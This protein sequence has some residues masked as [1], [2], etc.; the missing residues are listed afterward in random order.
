MTMSILAAICSPPGDASDH[1]FDA[2]ARACMASDRARD[3]ALA[4]AEKLRDA[5][6][7]VGVEHYEGMIHVFFAFAGVVDRANEA[8]DVAAAALRDAL[9]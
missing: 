8:M 6:V 3:D 9:A 4:Y 7:P 2:A 5:G 1:V